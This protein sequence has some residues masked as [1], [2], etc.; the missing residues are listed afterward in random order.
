MKPWLYAYL[1]FATL[2][3]LVQFYN[4]W[5][6]SYALGGTLMTLVSAGL[7]AVVTDQLVM[8]V[9]ENCNLDI[10]GEAALQSSELGSQPYVIMSVPVVNILIDA[11]VP[12]K[13]FLT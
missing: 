10:H 12:A 13:L 2:A 3:L 6:D 1:V 8:H 5:N 11:Y 7:A 4:F 9:E